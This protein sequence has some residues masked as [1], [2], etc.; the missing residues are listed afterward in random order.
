MKILIIEDDQLIA[1]IYRNKFALDGFQAET[2]CDGDIGLEMARTFRP[3][4]ILLDLVLPKVNGL[5]VMRQLRAQKD[6]EELPVIVFSNTYLSNMVQ[7]AWKAGATKC[8]SKAN[9]T[10]K[11]VIEVLRTTL[12]LGGASNST[13]STVKTAVHTTNGKH[14][15]AAR[16]QKGSTAAPPVAGDAQFQADLVKTFT[17]NLP[18]TLNAMRGQL[19]GL[20]KAE[21][22][23]GRI[24]HL[25]DLYRRIHALTSNAAVVGL[26][27]F[28]HVADALEALLKELLEKPT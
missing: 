22:D 12:N 18:T 16:S 28:T 19:Q 17:Q 7:E 25:Q 6:F 20:I 23:A 14:P 8:L 24:K 3:D 21:N 27:H 2:A 1:N 4:A 5:E 13:P 11:Q 26:S 15:T 9:C 10:P